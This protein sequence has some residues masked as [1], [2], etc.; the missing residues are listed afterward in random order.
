MVIIAV[1]IMNCYRHYGK[2]FSDMELILLYSQKYEN[3]AQKSYF[4][5]LGPASVVVKALRSRNNQN[6]RDNGTRF[7]L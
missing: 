5:I 2:T 6:T 3:D 7:A 4:A 1:C